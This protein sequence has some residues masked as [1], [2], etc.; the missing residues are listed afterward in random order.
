MEKDACGD[1]CRV[2]KGP[3]HPTPFPTFFSSVQ[4]VWCGAIAAQTLMCDYYLLHIAWWE[5]WICV[6]LAHFNYLSL[7]Q[8]LDKKSKISGKHCS[9]TALFGPKV[10]YIGPKR[11]AYQ[12]F[13][14]DVEL[15][16]SVAC[17]C[18]SWPND[19]IYIISRFILLICCERTKYV[20]AKRKGN[21]FTNRCL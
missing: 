15:V 3:K 16:L 14:D 8:V 6:F 17:A 19:L 7:F 13:K 12:D 11:Q 21:A 9:F 2:E 1:K 20:S 4:L 10:S 18:V 5:I